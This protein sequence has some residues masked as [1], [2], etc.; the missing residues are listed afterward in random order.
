MNEDAVFKTRAGQN[1]Y[2]F[3]CKCSLCTSIFIVHT[4]MSYSSRSLRFE[5]VNYFLNVVPFID[6]MINNYLW[7][8]D[9]VKQPTVERLQSLSN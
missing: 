6:F 4:N 1:L 2:L 7:S 5:S 9:Y 8:M 3:L